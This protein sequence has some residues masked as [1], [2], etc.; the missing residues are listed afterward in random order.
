MTVVVDS[1][2]LMRRGRTGPFSTASQ[3]RLRD[4]AQG[5][6]GKARSPINPKRAQRVSGDWGGEI[7]EHVKG[8][9]TPTLVHTK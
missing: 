8:L 7:I 6:K 4:G 9:G 2:M 1:A 5:W 3:A